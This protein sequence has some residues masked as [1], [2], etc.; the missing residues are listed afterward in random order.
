MKIQPTATSGHREINLSLTWELT[1]CW[2][3]LQCWKL[4]CRLL[5]EKSRPWSYSVVDPACCSLSLTDKMYM[6]EFHGCYG[7]SQLFSEGSEAYSTGGN[8]Y[9]YLV[10]PGTTNLVKNPYMVGEATGS[11]GVLSSVVLLNG[12]ST[13]PPSS[14]VCTHK[15]P[16][17]N[18]GQ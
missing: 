16:A 4:Q 3:V 17:L 9:R 14:Y 6:E 2:L 10:I 11:R 13:K 18:L 8:S 12:H 5:G 15:H 1:S 7:G